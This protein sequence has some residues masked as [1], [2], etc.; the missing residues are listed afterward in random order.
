MLA[1]NVR[2]EGFT[3]TDWVR[4]LNL[5]RPLR[6]DERPRDPQRARGLVVLVHHNGRVLKLVHSKVGRLRLDD[7]ARDW[8]LT[9]EELAQRH[10]ASWALAIEHG[11]LD[12]VMAD[13]GRR[14]QRTDDMT[15][16]WLLLID[17]PMQSVLASA[18]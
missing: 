18:A 16:Q 12:A 17:A 4:V 9:T 3:H 7:V 15:A 11:A 1:P 5:F 2:F 6:E 10:D 13:L 8:P 14:L